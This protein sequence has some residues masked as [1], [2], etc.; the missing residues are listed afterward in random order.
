M[1]S[2]GGARAAR[3]S[4]RA[5]KPSAK[6][7]A[8]RDDVARRRPTPRTC[9][10]AEQ[11][12]A[13]SPQPLRPVALAPVEGGV[14]VK[15][16]A[17][18]TPSAGT[19]RRDTSSG[20]AVTAPTRKRK[21]R[22]RPGPDDSGSVATP[23]GLP[24]ELVYGSSAQACG[25][26][27]DG[28]RGASVGEGGVSKRHKHEQRIRDAP[29]SAQ[30]PADIGDGAQQESCSVEAPAEEVRVDAGPDLLTIALN[31]DRYTTSSIW[32]TLAPGAHCPREQ[33]SGK[34][35]DSIENHTHR[36]Q[37]RGAQ[38][39]LCQA[40]KLWNKE[41]YN[42]RRDKKGVF[43]LKLPNV[44]VPEAA[45]ESW[46]DAVGG[47]LDGLMPDQI[48]HVTHGL[49][50]ESVPECAQPPMGD[51]LAQY[52]QQ[53]VCARA[54]E[55]LANLARQSLLRRRQMGQLP[56]E[57]QGVAADELETTICDSIAKRVQ[58]RG[59]K[60]PVWFEQTVKEHVREALSNSKE[61]CA[62]QP[63]AV[64]AGLAGVYV[65][66]HGPLAKELRTPKADTQRGTRGRDFAPDQKE[67][68]AKIVQKWD[69]E[70]HKT[71]PKNNRVE[72]DRRNMWQ[73]ETGTSGQRAKNLF[74]TVRAQLPQLMSKMS[75]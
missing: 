23:K 24:Q 59:G 17:K 2:Q 74:H 53:Q 20:G 9:D 50:R 47:N 57:G 71:F 21:G 22:G 60:M 70:S 5:R 42:N 67:N 62:G 3:S 8:R 49:M 30:T 39:A 12:G 38:Q 7:Q 43:A 16:K 51:C 46:Q 31:A 48:F 26:A 61:T 19:K 56:A 33:R 54:R 55:R 73:R 29:E 41:E 58:M 15:K 10:P 64:H 75:L 35:V 68:A 34:E 37:R 25:D 45:A 65:P 1:P 13:A 63:S 11:G 44:K 69:G 4:A 14:P 36:Y 52:V 28:G 32:Q 27:T 66:H 72:E 40:G 6:E 18:K